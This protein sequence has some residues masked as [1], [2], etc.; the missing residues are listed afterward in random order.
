MDSMKSI[1]GAAP[2]QSGEAK[3]LASSP[4][5]SE[6]ASAG[7][8]TDSATISRRKK[9]RKKKAEGTS[10]KIAG[11][12]GTG[13]GAVKD[14]KKADTSK[15]SVQ[16]SAASVTEATEEN[17]S[18]PGDP[19][20][21]LESAAKETDS[22]ASFLLRNLSRKSYCDHIFQI[23]RKM[24]KRELEGKDFSKAA[25]DLIEY[26]Y[27]TDDPLVRRVAKS[28][29]CDKTLIEFKT[30]E[31][32]WMYRAGPIDG[33]AKYL[34][35]LR[36]DI[37]R[38]SNRY[39]LDDENRIPEFLRALARSAQGMLIP[40]H[41]LKAVAHM[42]HLLSARADAD[43]KE[44]L[45]EKEPREKDLS[46]AGGCASLVDF[47]W[48][49]GQLE[50]LKDGAV[51][52][53]GSLDL[54]SMVM[55][56]KVSVRGSTIVIESPDKK[57]SP[58]NRK[59]ARDILKKLSPW[60]KD[61]EKKEGIEKLH[62]L[63]SGDPQKAAGVMG[64]MVDEVIQNTGKNRRFHGAAEEF[65]LL[66]DQA[67]ENS[68]LRDLLA[69]C[70]P[71]LRMIPQ[72]ADSFDVIAP[73][74]LTGGSYVE[75][76]EKLVSLFPET[77]NSTFVDEALSPLILTEEPNTR[78]HA[79]RFV[80]ELW[81][82][83]PDMAAC[84]A[85]LILE[86]QDDRWFDDGL[87]DILCEAAEK[88]DWVPDKAQMEN[89]V[90][91]LY[92]PPG[93]E[94]ESLFDG[95]GLKEGDV[96]GDI[97][98]F[99]ILLAKDPH[100]LQNWQLPD[101]KG[102]M[103]SVERALLDR[104][105]ND[106]H[107]QKLEHLSIKREFNSDYRGKTS[108][109]YQ[110]LFH[111]PAIVDD[112]LEKLRQGYAR[113]GMLD[114]MD[115]G[116]QASLVMLASLG[117][118][119]PHASQLRDI[120]FPARLQKQ[121]FSEILNPYR[122]E[123]IQ[124]SLKELEEGGLPAGEFFEKAQETLQIAHCIGYGSDVVRNC[125]GVLKSINTGIKKLKDRGK[126]EIASS[127]N[128][129]RKSFAGAGKIDA[130]PQS[131]FLR[132]Q[133]L[134]DLGRSDRELMKELHAIVKPFLLED[135]GC[136]GG[137]IWNLMDDIMDYEIDRNKEEITTGNLKLADRAALTERNFTLI[138]AEHAYKDKDK[139]KTETMKA[140]NEWFAGI[141]APVHPGELDVRF[142][143]TEKA[144]HVFISL[145]REAERDED[146]PGIWVSYRDILDRVGGSGSADMALDGFRYVREMMARG[147]S[148]EKA[149]AHAI[150]SYALGADPRNVVMDD[151]RITSTLTTVEE[152]EDAV[153]IAGLKLD[154]HR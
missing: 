154:I 25:Q 42:G 139:K 13:A 5:A 27:Y 68:W 51:V 75:F 123:E 72:W 100:V 99:A 38:D 130:M 126:K 128:E 118:K 73:D 53:P 54:K 103:V 108:N 1:T 96:A 94:K 6:D 102:T 58:V 74:N 106:P 34:E 78:S 10:K 104:V 116:E 125:S 33:P 113:T 112:L 142:P 119:E 24:E 150:K 12:S 93:H 134:V 87:W 52:R 88:Y 146:I 82:E 20:T 45:R 84:T 98:L 46:W 28:A 11:S 90:A 140:F 149:L 8:I 152:E 79:C 9:S 107:D 95:G 50:V 117:L 77:L 67:K 83:N 91:R 111:D 148:R 60:G 49:N 66:L 62:Q 32:N 40:A 59:I 120:L 92:H 21:V 41:A 143:D 36:N 132:F 23:T 57:Y 16:S 105:M 80:K 26:A 86:R 97:R 17:P 151:E 129:F 63:S 48:G 135:Q 30:T 110:I 137:L 18:L 44:S 127:I 39:Y 2:L 136:H 133:I 61:E 7:V 122:S 65:N 55:K 47:W 3:K 69:P 19:D 64:A 70:L 37:E 71:R 141:C 145:S 56:E 138:E 153:N 144:Y 115:S 29:L 15:G 85:S 43:L 76:C 121:G 35:R 22:P 114:R 81:K 31:S 124:K 14:D 109:L 131:D 147:R 4:V 101:T 89:L